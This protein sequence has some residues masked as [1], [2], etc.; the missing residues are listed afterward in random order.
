[1]KARQQ[2]MTAFGY[3]RLHARACTAVEFDEVPLKQYSQIRCIHI[4]N[5]FGMV[6]EH[7]RGELMWTED[8]RSPWQPNGPPSPM[9]A[10]RGCGFVVQFSYLS[11][12]LF[13]RDAS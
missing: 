13:D 9:G 10:T 7:E 3:S 11:R 2:C 1:M 12:A 4:R 8:S 6:D 5:S